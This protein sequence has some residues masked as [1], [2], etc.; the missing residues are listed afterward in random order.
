MQQLSVPCR[1]FSYLLRL[2]TKLLTCFGVSALLCAGFCVLFLAQRLA[3]LLRQIAFASSL[4]TLSTILA[5]LSTPFL[6]GPLRQ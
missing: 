4:L 3:S 5:R 6:F 2:L 1:L